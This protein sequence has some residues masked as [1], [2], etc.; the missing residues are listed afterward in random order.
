MAT[1]VDGFDV[2]VGVLVRVGVRTR[3]KVGAR[4]RA[5]AR[6]RV[7]AKVTLQT[8]GSST[9]RSARAHSFMSRSK[10]CCSGVQWHMSRVT[11]T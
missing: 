10:R 2:D 11:V 4:A 7:R 8:S 9:L 1:A 5:R 3:V 6:A